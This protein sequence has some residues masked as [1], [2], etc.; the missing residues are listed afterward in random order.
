MHTLKVDNACSHR[1]VLGRRCMYGFNC[2]RVVCCVCKSSLIRSN[3]R[4]NSNG[5]RHMEQQLTPVIQQRN[6]RLIDQQWYPIARQLTEMYRIMI[7]KD[8]QLNITDCLHMYCFVTEQL[9]QLYMCF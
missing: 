3:A 2:D 7:S 9:L 1:L 5:I 8:K 6:N 4:Q